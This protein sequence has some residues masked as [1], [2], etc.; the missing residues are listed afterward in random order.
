MLFSKQGPNAVDLKQEI[1]RRVDALPREQQHSVVQFLRSLDPAAQPDNGASLA[2]FAG[3]LDNVSAAEMSAAIEA[4]C[5]QV[6][7]GQW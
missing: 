7:A 6:D 2:R 5:E 3:T 4:E 1:L